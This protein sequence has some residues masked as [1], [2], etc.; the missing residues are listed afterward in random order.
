MEELIS[1]LTGASYNISFKNPICYSF[2]IQL[3]AGT[4]SI[5]EDEDFMEPRIVSMDLYVFGTETV[6]NV[7]KN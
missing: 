1:A 5:L 2:V 4:Q 6:E 7:V 3:P